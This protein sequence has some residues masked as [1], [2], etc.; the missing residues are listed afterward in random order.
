MK[1]NNIRSSIFL[2]LTAL[3]WGTAFVF[4]SK[5][6]DYMQP[7]TF[8]AAR[9]FLGFLVLIPVV[10]V[11]IIKTRKSVT[12]SKISLKVTLIGGISCG[13]AMTV[14][15]LFQQY[16]VKYTTVGKAGFITTLYII[17]TPILGIFLKRKCPFN[18][19]IGA[20]LS[21]IGMYF[22]CI[23]DEFSI[24]IGD[25]LVFIS[26]IVFAVHILVIDYF[27]VKTSCVMLSCIQFF[28]CFTISTV[29]AVIFDTPSLQQ[30]LDGIIPVLYA[31]IISSGVAYTLQ[32]I[33]QK[34]FNPTAAA[35]ILSIES[36]ISAF[37]S[38]VA[39]LFGFLTQDQSMTVLQIVGCLIV[40]VAVI[41]VQIPVEKLNAHINA[42]RK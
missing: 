35:M 20:I 13:L 21:I 19:W 39:Y 40:F 33:G 5:G 36:V 2:F 1:N 16:G 28:V 34:N 25:L 11:E 3:I 14:A 22:L 4:Q 9:N 26:A 27:S 31:G 24:S 41:F 18:V 17:I 12:K 32:I 42:P 10:F 6:N 23:I 15:S 37:S 29:L 8:S 7:F 30:I 38:Y